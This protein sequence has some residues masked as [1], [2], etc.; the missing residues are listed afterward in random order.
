MDHHTVFFFKT[1]LNGNGTYLN[2]G[3][4]GEGCKIGR[5]FRSGPTRHY[6]LG[7]LTLKSKR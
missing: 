3:G 2:E 6:V 5:S 1:Q 7:Y 4:D